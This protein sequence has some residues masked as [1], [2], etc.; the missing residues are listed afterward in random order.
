MKPVNNKSV[1]AHLFSLLEQVQNDEV[2]IEKAIASTK[3]TN[4]LNK[5]FKYEVDRADVKMRIEKHNK[6]FNSNIE[7]REVESKNFE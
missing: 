6:E 5:C 1:A 3:I 4:E 7:L 2:S